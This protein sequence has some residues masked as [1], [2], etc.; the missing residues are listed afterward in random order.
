M[1]RNARASC[2]SDRPDRRPR[3]DWRSPRTRRRRKPPAPAT[4][5]RYFTSIDGLMDGNADVILKETRQGKTVTAATLDV[6]YPAEKGS[7]RKDRF[8][9]NLAVSGQTLTGTRAKPGR[10]IAGDGETHPQ[11]DRRQLR[12]QG[13][14]QRRPDRDRGRIDRQFRPQRKG[15]PGQPVDRGQ[16]R[17]R[18]RRISPK[19]RRKSIGVKVKLDA[20]AGFPEE[21]ARAERRGRRCPA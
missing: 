12:I 13:P 17:A 21:P 18:R 7:D 5:T 6:C 3:P 1:R 4:E 9:A 2:L 14:D 15:I 8:V 11:A 19:C 20:A 16:H 10:Q